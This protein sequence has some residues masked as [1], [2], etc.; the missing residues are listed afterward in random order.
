MTVRRRH[1]TKPLPTRWLL[2][3]ERLGE[4]LWAAIAA[5]PR[6]AGIVFRHHGLPPD[7]RLALARA[8][9]AAAK[10]RG[11]LVVLAEAPAGLRAD[12]Q[13]RSRRT[14]RRLP[15]HGII[16]ASAH[17][18]RELQAA[19]RAGADLLFL[20]PVFATASHPGASCLG[21]VRFGL[22]ARRTPCPVI[23]LGGMTE[24]RFS[25]LRQ[26]G[27][28]GFAAIDHWASFQPPRASSFSS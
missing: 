21:P 11:L 4:G 8:V 26:M 15:R 10:S 2:T 5:L 9:V 23:A 20:S 25:R 28:Y 18:A 17:S 24:Q 16:T 3:D 22:L 14:R 13:H 12:G 6:G 19:A 1:S 27:A 7:E